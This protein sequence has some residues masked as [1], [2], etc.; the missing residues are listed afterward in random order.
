LLRESD[1]PLFA[2]LLLS[3]LGC[4]LGHVS[5][6]PFRRGVQFDKKKGAGDAGTLFRITAR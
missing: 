1:L 2:A 6:P 5:C 3:A 4:F